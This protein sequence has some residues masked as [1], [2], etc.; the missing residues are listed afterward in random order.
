MTKEKL[1]FDMEVLSFESSTIKGGEYH[2]QLKNILSFLLFSKVKKPIQFTHVSHQ[3]SFHSNVSLLDNLMPEAAVELS[4]EDRLL[5]LQEKVENTGNSFLFELFRSVK[6][7]DKLPCAVDKRSRKIAGLL[8]GFL[9]KAPFLIIELPELHLEEK[10]KILVK[11]AIEFELK[12]KSHSV[13]LT[14]SEENL[15]SSLLTKIISH[16]PNKPFE[17]YDLKKSQR[18][19]E[20]K[21]A[22]SSVLVFRA[23]DKLAS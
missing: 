9:E 8:K 4:K 6:S 14:S 13:I 10:D 20:I 17:V 11:S 2:T 23:K 19:Q 3:G 7:W 21:P 22:S 1:S 16:K 12:R 15:W 5:S 18:P